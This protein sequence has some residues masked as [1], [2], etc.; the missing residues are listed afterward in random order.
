[1]T[2]LPV[3][4]TTRALLRGSRR[5]HAWMLAHRTCRRNTNPHPHATTATTRGYAPGIEDM[6]YAAA[7][8]RT[9]NC[10]RDCSACQRSY[11]ICWCSQLSAVVSNAIDRRIAI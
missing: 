8:F 7:S 1:M 3:G 10:F 6:A 4:I 2:A 5:A 11:C 9:R